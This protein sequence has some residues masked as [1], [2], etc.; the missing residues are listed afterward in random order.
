M[1]EKTWKVNYQIRSRFVSV[2]DENGKR[3]GN[4]ILDN[5]V[6]LAQSKNLDLVQVSDETAS[7]VICK[8]SDF[9]KM[10]YQLGK[11][12]K[13]NH[14]IK[15]KEILISMNIAE[16]DLATKLNKIKEFLSKKYEIMFGIKYKNHKDKNNQSLAKEK[17]IECLGLLNVDCSNLKFMYAQDKIFVIFR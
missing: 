7:E 5:A 2:I 13:N 6:Q 11:T 9:G 1:S 16:N 15:K 12:R 3:I 4:M 17:I 14:V 10:K 8:I